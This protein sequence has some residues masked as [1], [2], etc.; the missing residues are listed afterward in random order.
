M[1]FGLS[2]KAVTSEANADF[3]SSIAPD[4]E[5]VGEPAEVRSPDS[6]TAIMASFHKPMRRHSK[7]DLSI[8]LDRAAASLVAPSRMG[9]AHL[10]P[11]I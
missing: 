3:L 10:S 8:W 5:A 1:G 7:D 6:D 4:F 11:D 2:V 9:L